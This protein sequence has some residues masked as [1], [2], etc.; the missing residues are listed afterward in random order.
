MPAPAGDDGAKQRLEGDKS[1]VALSRNCTPSSARRVAMGECQEALI[2]RRAM[3]R[4]V[5]L[6]ALITML[7]ATFMWT[8]DAWARA[9]G[10]GSSG[11]RGSGTFYCPVNPG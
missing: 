8:L 6:T 7:L 9:G 3:K 1:R 10:G 11:S 2:R 4:S 5:V